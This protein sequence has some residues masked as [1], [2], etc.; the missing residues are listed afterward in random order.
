METNPPGVKEK[1]KLHPQARRVLKKNPRE[2]KKPR[3]LEKN[4]VGLKILKEE[5]RTRQKE[6]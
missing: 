6:V 3:E 1:P 2:L 5:V 4:P